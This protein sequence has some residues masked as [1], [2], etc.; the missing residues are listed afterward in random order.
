MIESVT[1]ALSILTV[2]GH[3]SIASFLLVLISCKYKMLSSVEPITSLRRIIEKDAISLAFIVALTAMLGS[4]FFSDVAGFDP[5]VLCWYQRIFMYP[6]VV[7]LGLAVR[8]KSD[9]IID[10]VLWLTGPG[11]LLAFYHYTQ[12]MST[13]LLLPCK[14]VGYSSSC[15]ERFF[16]HFGYITIPLMSATAFAMIFLLLLIRKLHIHKK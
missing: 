10:Y 14:I 5:C 13:N 16:T 4:L 7:L 8:K 1:K 6:N 9:E 12:Q 11:A 3:V 2:F 15:S